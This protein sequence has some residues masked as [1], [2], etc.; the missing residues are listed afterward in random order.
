MNDLV[1]ID[2][3]VSFWACV[4]NRYSSF[5]PHFET[6]ADLL[7]DL[8]N[9]GKPFKWTG[10]EE[11]ASQT[12]KRSICDS[13]GLSYLDASREICLQTDAS[14]LGLRAVLFHE[15][16]RGTKDIIKYAIRKL[17]PAEKKYCTTKKEALAEVWAVG[18]FGGYLEGRK[19]KL[20]T[21]NS[22][23]QWLNKVSGT[24]SKLMRWAY[25]TL[26]SF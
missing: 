4:T 23:L 20:F 12:I 24:K 8:L 13:P 6:K 14:D 10:K 5:V 1:P 7:T 21:N 22:F 19:F 15:R 9:N 2:R 3:C 11:E 17:S 16:E 25:L 26:R 18:K